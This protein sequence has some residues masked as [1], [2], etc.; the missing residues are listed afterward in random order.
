MNRYLDWEHR[1]NDYLVTVGSS[2]TPGAQVAWGKMDCCIYVAG[3]VEA[4]T[5][6]DPM[7]DFRGRYRTSAGAL[8]ALRKIGSGD[9]RSTLATR[10]GTEKPPAS[11]MRGDIGYSDGACGI[12]IGKITLFLGA[13]GVVRFPTLKLEC[14]YSV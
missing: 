14:A 2:I 7:A 1:L 4:I 10:L 12:V 9:L 11:A 6:T 3:A 13:G 5:G 8:R